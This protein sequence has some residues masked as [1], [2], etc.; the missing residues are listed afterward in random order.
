MFLSNK[1]TFKYWCYLNELL[2][3]FSFCHS[4]LIEYAQWMHC[5]FR[6]SMLESGQDR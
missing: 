4:I 2:K 1:F 3:S 5:T 6:F